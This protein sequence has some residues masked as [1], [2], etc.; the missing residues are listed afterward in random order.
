MSNKTV[1]KTDRMNATT[2]MIVEALQDEKIF[3][4]NGKWIPA[5]EIYERVRKATGVL[6]Q[7]GSIYHAMSVRLVAQGLGNWEHNGE[8]TRGS[9]YRRVPPMPKPEPK[10]PAKPAPSEEKGYFSRCIGKVMADVELVSD[11]QDVLK[12]QMDRIEARLIALLK[13]LGVVVK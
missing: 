6:Y 2:R 12:A 11:K 1:I 10:A 9:K 8:A 13:E 4:L 3:P 7:N 5:D